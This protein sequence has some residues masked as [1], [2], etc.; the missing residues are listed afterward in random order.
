VTDFSHSLTCCCPSQRDIKSHTD[1]ILHFPSTETRQR[2]VGCLLTD[3]CMQAWQP[4]LSPSVHSCW[5]LFREG[6]TLL[7]TISTLLFHLFFGITVLQ[8]LTDNPCVTSSSQ[9]TD[10]ETM[11]YMD[12]QKQH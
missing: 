6:A 2:K 7:L 12:I 1:C 4:Y 9:F 8:L 5:C 10:F 11:L 3:V